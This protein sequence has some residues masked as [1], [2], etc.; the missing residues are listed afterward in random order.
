MPTAAKKTYAGL[1]TTT[2]KS[3]TLKQATSRPIP[4]K[5]STP[6]ST[7]GR[8]TKL[9]A[10]PTRTRSRVSTIKRQVRSAT[11]EGMRQTTKSPMPV[12]NPATANLTPPAP[13]PDRTTTKSSIIS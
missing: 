11:T 13:L 9:A 3:V 8:V 4:T 12:V 6:A 5:L 2:S 10:L 1:Q 7:N